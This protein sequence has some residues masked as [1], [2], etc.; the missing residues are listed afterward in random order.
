MKKIYKLFLFAVL[1]LAA[2]SASAV[3]VRNMPVNKIQPN[4]DTVHFF[5][6]GDEFYHRYHDSLDYTIVQDRAG[7]WVYAIAAKD[8]SIQPSDYRAGKL[9]P[10]HLGINPETLGFVPGLSISQEEYQ[11]RRKEWEIPEQYRVQ[12]P[13]TSGRNH[14]DFCNLVIFIRFSDDSSYSRSLES[15][16]KMFSDSSRNNSVSLYNYFK[17]ASYNK[18]FMRT[19]YAPT[20]DSNTILSYQSPHPR[21]Y[22][23]PYNDDNTLGYTNSDDRRSRE[24]EL[25]VG[26]V[27]WINDSAPVPT[28]YNLDCDNDGYIDNV[29]FVVRGTYTGWSDLLWPHKWNLYGH[30]V[31]I[32]GKQVN[33]FNFAL[34]GAG[35]DYFGPSTFCHEMFHSLSAPDLYHYQTEGAGTPVGV[36]DLMASNS[37]PPQH[38]LAWLKYKYGNWLDSIPTVTEPGVYTLTSNADSVPGTM[39][40]KFPSAHPDQFYV[41]EYRDNTETFETTLPGK[42]LLIYRVDTRFDGN[43]NFNGYDYFNEVWIFRP[44][45][46]S[47]WENGSLAEAYFNPSRGRSEFSPATNPYPYL[48]DG[49]RDMTFAITGI[50]TP[51]YNCRFRYTNRTAPA[52]LTPERITSHSA[53]LNWLGVGEAYRVYYR[54]KDSDMV[55]KEVTTRIPHI[56]LTDLHPNVVYEWTVRALYDR[57][58]TNT[59]A[60][61]STLAAQATFHTELCN[62]PNTDTVGWYTIEQSSVIP[63]TYNHGYNYFQQIVD[64]DELHGE[65]TISTLTF[66]YAHT[67]ALTKDSCVIYLGTTTMDHFNDSV[68][69]IPGQELQQVYAGSLH[70]EQ[71]WN[72]LV[73]SEPFHYNGTD[74]LV[75]AIDDNSGSPSRIG[76]KFYTNAT[77]NWQS[78]IKTSSSENPD[79]MVDSTL[80]GGAS[81][82][83]RIN[84]KFTGCPNNNGQVYACVISDNNS[85]GFAS[86]GGLC[87]VGD[88]ISVRAYPEY[89]NI[90]VRWHDN[91]TE[92]PRQMV[93]TS[94][95]L[96]I[97]YFHS[98]VGIDDIDNDSDGMG[99]NGYIVM[100]QQLSIAVSGAER[101]NVDVYDLMG[102]RIAHADANHA[103]P[104]R[105]DV[106]AQ[107]V[108][109]LRV[110]ENKPVK[111]FVSGR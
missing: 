69:Y 37:K 26:A 7:Y 32:N 17:H 50:T 86:G 90:F 89:G 23:M 67:T 104:V 35:A 80:A 34:E 63:F 18:I 81:Y 31:F 54:P 68:R 76:E 65:K 71:G 9:S 101:Q 74:N 19:Y 30:D 4:G 92:N 27:N 77:A 107:G 2:N 41:V 15:V 52:D 84:M 16:D 10:G 14:G 110:G 60:D 47:D 25:L 72:E 103:D 83:S 22:Y 73:L 1:L 20:P 82:S 78:Y 58:D 95:T 109:I 96:I 111:L 39:A 53:T 55:Y 99:Q 8:G 43:A 49:T 40:L 62:N 29:N 3:F 56:T 45:A 38:S 57:V 105:F 11:Q 48:S 36:W 108:Y 28:S 6:T 44:N 94:D 85:L 12:L 91:N 70:F 79:P 66:H 21:A 13:K 97:A 5:V 42:G 87:D 106:P 46:T 64:A 59:F 102:R 24:F 93:I 51:G 100:T 88:A 33:T 98:P 61:S 75:V